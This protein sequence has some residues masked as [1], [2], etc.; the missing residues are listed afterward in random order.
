[1]HVSGEGRAMMRI[2]IT[3]RLSREALER[4]L[5]QPASAAEAKELYA[6]AYREVQMLINSKGE[7]YVWRLATNP[8]V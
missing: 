6:Q 5:R 8:P 1:M 3:Q 4:K 7:A 2:K